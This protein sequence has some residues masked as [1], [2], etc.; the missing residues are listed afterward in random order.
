MNKNLDEFIKSLDEQRFYDAHESIESIWFPR[1]FEDSDEM[2]LLKGFIN[3]SVSFE[4]YKKG[5]IEPSKRVWK[6]YIKYRPLLYKIDSKYLNRYH[7][8]A[9]YIESIE[10]SIRKK[11]AKL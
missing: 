1:R 10:K 5:R 9:R 6:N 3:A 2:R 11:D 8:I 4:L 7:Y